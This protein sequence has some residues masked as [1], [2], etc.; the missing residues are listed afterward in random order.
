M[1]LQLHH[2]LLQT[3]FHIVHSAHQGLL[4][5]D[6]LRQLEG[7]FFVAVLPLDEISVA[8]LPDDPAAEPLLVELAGY[9]VHDASVDRL[10][11]A[12]PSAA[13]R[14]STQCFDV[15]A[16]IADRNVCLEDK[17]EVD[18]LVR[19]SLPAFLGELL[20]D[21]EQCERQRCAVVV[22]LEFGHACVEL[23]HGHRNSL[24]WTDSQARDFGHV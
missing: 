24:V 6:M 7:V 3:V 8:D 22:L 15:R 18:A 13:R 1:V 11:S 21:R 17:A 4:Q 23:C 12:V 5:P 2:I 9:G 19:R 10:L 16:H 20:L 14:D